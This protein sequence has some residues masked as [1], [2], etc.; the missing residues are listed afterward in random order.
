MRVDIAVVMLSSYSCSKLPWSFS[1]LSIIIN[2]TICLLSLGICAPG[3][4]VLADRP[5]VLHPNELIL[6]NISYL[7]Q[8]LTIAKQ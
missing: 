8:M 2:L 7:A 5:H 3:L 1:I 4:Q 6:S